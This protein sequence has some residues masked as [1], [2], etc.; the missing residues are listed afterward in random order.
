MNFETTKEILF[1][2]EYYAKLYRSIIRR[3][4]KT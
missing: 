1:S 4:S 3:W 2:K